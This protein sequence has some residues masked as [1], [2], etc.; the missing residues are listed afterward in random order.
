MSV[1]IHDLYIYPIKSFRGLRVDTLKIESR[2]PL[3]DRQ[4]M[5]VDRTGQMITLRQRSELARFGVELVGVKAGAGAEAGSVL[6][7]S[8]G[9]S[10]VQF[11]VREKEGSALNVR[12]WN[13][14]VAAFEVRAEVSAWLSERLS[15]RLSE[16]VRLVRMVD[17]A[18]LAV[19]EVYGVDST[20]GTVITG[21]SPTSD[22]V[23]TNARTRNAPGELPSVRFVDS[24]PLLVISLA[25][26]RELERRVGTEMAMERFR[27]NIVLDGPIEPH[28]EDTWS[29]IECGDFQ[30]NSVKPC[31]RC[32]IT[33]LDPWTG[34]GG[35]EPLRT[36]A[37]YRR[38]ESG[39]VF[40]GQYYAPSGKGDLKKCQVLFLAT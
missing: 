8:L 3:L 40:F 29:S 1:A 36:L 22:G 6:R 31:S 12:V 39:K 33:T 26:L 34:A 19:D 35:V 10:S 37:T 28:A 5:L 30:L 20:G 15:E 17:E 25:S 18:D 23:A 27:P 11:G 32:K 24:Q 13:R 9:A 2:G 4:W 16:E 14:T 7:L 21:G 38:S